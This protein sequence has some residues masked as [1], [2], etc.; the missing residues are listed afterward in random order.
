[1]RVDQM[2]DY[3]KEVTFNATV[4]LQR[5]YQKICCISEQCQKTYHHQNLFCQ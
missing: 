5:I 3:N 1:M 4:S 2:I